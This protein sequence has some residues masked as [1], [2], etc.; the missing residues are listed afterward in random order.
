MEIR[1]YMK[2]CDN[3]MNN[4]SNVPGVGSVIDCILKAMD[5]QSLHILLSFRIHDYPSKALFAI[6]L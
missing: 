4:D 3:V 5:L 6:I 2:A 1:T